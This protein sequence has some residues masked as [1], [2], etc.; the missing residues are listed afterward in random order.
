MKSYLTKYNFCYKSSSYKEEKEIRLICH[1]ARSF[2]KWN[3]LE[4]PGTYLYFDDNRL[5]LYFE[6]DCYR[7]SMQHPDVYNSIEINKLSMTSLE[8]RETVKKR[9]KKFSKQF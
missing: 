7:Q 8:I 9:Y 2:N 4:N 6:Q 5:Y 3:G 1:I